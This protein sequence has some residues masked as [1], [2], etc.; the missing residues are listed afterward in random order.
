MQ[1]NNSE[2]FCSNCLGVLE[3]NVVNVGIIDRSPLTDW[4]FYSRFEIVGLGC[5][6]WTSLTLLTKIK[7]CVA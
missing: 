2:S 1:H 4:V 3:G 6:R 5:L 7:E